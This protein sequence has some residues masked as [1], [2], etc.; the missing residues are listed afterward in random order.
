MKIIDK[1]KSTMEKFEQIEAGEC[2]IDKQGE[3]NIKTYDPEREDFFAVCLNNG[4]VWFPDDG[5]EYEIVLA[6]VVIE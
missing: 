4:E 1:R 2:F 6:K 5:C 3:I